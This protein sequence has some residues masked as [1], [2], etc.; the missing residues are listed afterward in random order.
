[1]GGQQSCF[2]FVDLKN[3]FLYNSVI[4][5]LKRKKIYIRGNW[6]SPYQYHVL[7]SGTYFKKFKYFSNI[8]INIYNNSRKKNEL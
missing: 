1:M 7:I 6:P 5:K 8:F 3:K 2:I 4:S